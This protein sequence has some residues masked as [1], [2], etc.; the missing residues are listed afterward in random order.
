M[1]GR[2]Y[3]LISSTNLIDVVASCLRCHAINVYDSGSYVHDKIN[4]ELRTAGLDVQAEDIIDV[5]NG[6]H[7]KG[8]GISA[9]EELGGYQHY[10]VPDYHV[11][12][13]HC[14]NEN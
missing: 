12:L 1:R 10:C 3:L 6:H 9:Q 5:I 11:S 8:Y 14:R 13:Y 7:G 4:E 2:W